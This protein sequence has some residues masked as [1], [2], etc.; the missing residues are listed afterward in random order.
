MNKPKV[1]LIGALMDPAL[2]KL[3]NFCSVKQWDEQQSIP[4]E[5]LMEWVA[6]AEGLIVNNS[7]TVNEELLQ[8][9]PRLKVIAQV[10]VGYDNVDIEA[11]SKYKIPFGNTP[12][13]LVDATANLAFS[14]LLCSTRRI[15]EGWDF[16]RSNSWALGHRLALG[17]DIA[18]K[19]LGIVG[20]GQIG[21]AV[22]Q[23]ANAFGMNV[24]Y[25]NRNRRQDDEKIGAAYQSFEFLLK[26]SDA[27]IV[28]TPLSQETRGLFGPAEFRKMKST[29][30]FINVSRGSVVDTDAL[31]EALQTGEI[32]YA[33]LDV[34]DPEP[35]AQDHPILKLSNILITPHIGS[36]TLETR[37]AMAQLTVDNILAGL[38][39]RPMA[40]CV[41]ASKITEKNEKP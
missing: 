20:M 41:N 18:G 12:G 19:T 13:V 34:T 14:L 8:H 26:E 25:Y 22:A 9:A 4:Q 17:T 6:D 16:I 3:Q 7:V 1:V 29:A 5:I 32:A 36:A 31:V 39:D 30:C 23:R 33:A 10:S 35:L 40:A 24:I 21:A 37:T 38:A 2:E 11:C 15:H 28:L 27:I